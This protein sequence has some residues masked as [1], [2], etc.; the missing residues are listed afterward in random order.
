MSAAL[1]PGCV[2]SIPSLVIERRFMSASKMVFNVLA[3]SFVL[4]M[5]GC[6]AVLVN[7]GSKQEPLTD[8]L[9]NPAESKPTVVVSADQKIISNFEDGSPNMNPQLYGAPAGKWNAF[10]YAGNTINM[11]FIVPGGANGTKMAAHISGTL[12]NKGDGSYP[13]FTLQGMFKDSGFFDASMFQG[14]QYYYKC[15]ADDKATARRFSV[16]I[17]ATLPTSNGGTCTD[18]CY[19]HFGA[20]LSTTGDWVLK[21]YAFSDL[22]RQPGWGSPVNPPDFTDHLTEIKTIE[23]SHNS[24]N[25]AGTYPI[26]YW[27]DEVQFF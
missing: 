15:P 22:K 8:G 13:A 2:T 20:D 1:E 10:S 7:E 18:A 17:A 16:T 4:S 25:T 27:V 24:Q 11:P 19:N 3:I 12:V 23:W 6:G 21:T 9:K 26:D 5:A 14:I